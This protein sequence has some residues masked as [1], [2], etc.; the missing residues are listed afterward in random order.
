[1]IPHTTQNHR[2]RRTINSH[3]PTSST[4]VTNKC[5][6]AVSSLMPQLLAI[7]TNQ[8]ILHGWWLHG[9]GRSSTAC[10]QA[11]FTTSCNVAHLIADI[12]H[13]TVLTVLGKMPRF[14]TVVAGSLILAICSQMTRPLTIPAQPG[15]TF[16]GGA[17]PCHMAWL[18]AKNTQCLIRTAL[19][20]MPRFLAVPA[21]GL[22]SAY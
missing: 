14:A 16:L 7:S 17:K 12:T 9:W 2:I 1:M 18:V 8:R 22:S 10:R 20:I 6:Q 5:K 19:R 11:R 21:N 4:I 13:G 15:V 3:V